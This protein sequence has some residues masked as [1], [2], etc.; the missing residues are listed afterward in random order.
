[1]TGAPKPVRPYRPRSVYEVVTTAGKTIEFDAAEVD[2]AGGHVV[3]DGVN[4]LVQW[5]GGPRG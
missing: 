4:A 2:R 3:I 1:M 5:R